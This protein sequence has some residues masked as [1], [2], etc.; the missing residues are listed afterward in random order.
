MRELVITLLVVCGLMAPGL[1]ITQNSSCLPPYCYRVYSEAEIDGFLFERAQLKTLETAQYSFMHDSIYAWYNG[2]EYERAIDSLNAWENCLIEEGD[3]NSL[4]YLV[5]VYDLSEAF[6]KMGEYRLADYYYRR[7]EKISSSEKHVERIKHLLVANRLVL[8]TKTFDPALS[9]LLSGFVRNSSLDN[10]TSNL[11]EEVPFGAT[12]FQEKEAFLQVIE[13]VQILKNQIDLINKEHKSPV[14][15][16]LS[17][18]HGLA[19]EMMTLMVSPSPTEGKEIAKKTVSIWAKTKDLYKWDRMYFSIAPLACLSL[20]LNG[21]PLQSIELITECVDRY[22]SIPGPERKYVYGYLKFPELFQLEFIRVIALTQSGEGSPLNLLKELRRKYA[23]QISELNSEL[24]ETYLDYQT[25]NLVYSYSERLEDID[26]AIYYLETGM[27]K[28][29]EKLAMQVVEKEAISASNEM[30]KFVRLGM[31]VC[32]YTYNLDIPWD[33]K[34]QYFN[35]AIRFFNKGVNLWLIRQGNFQDMDGLGITMSKEYQKIEELKYYELELNKKLLKGEGDQEYLRAEL[36]SCQIKQHGLWETIALENPFLRDFLL[37]SPEVHTNSIQSTL[38]SNE[39]ILLLYEMDG[40]IHKLTIQKDT[41]RFDTS[42]FPV[43]SEFLPFYQ[44]D[45]LT[46]QMIDQSSPD[47]LRIQA[48]Q[49][50]TKAVWPFK[51]STEKDLPYKVWVI[52]VGDLWGVPF[53]ALTYPNDDPIQDPDYLLYHHEISFLP[54]FQYWKL[55]PND[56]PFSD[57]VCIVPGYANGQDTEATAHAYPAID[58]FY[59]RPTEHLLELAHSLANDFDFQVLT[60]SNT[61]PLNVL[62]LMQNAGFIYLGAHASGDR[63]NLLSSFFSL[64]PAGLEP[65]TGQLH[66]FEIYNNRIAAELVVLAGCNSGIGRHSYG[67]GLLSTARAFIAAGSRSVVMAQWEAD[68]VATAAIHRD[69]IQM[70]MDGQ[71]K[72]SALREA[73]LNYLRNAGSLRMKAPYYWAAFQ[74][75]GDDAPLPAKLKSSGSNLWIYLPIG[76]LG[77]FIMFWMIRKRKRREE[78]YS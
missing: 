39:A 27:A 51:N 62:N 50:L 31:Q 33:K 47:S 4:D 40:V 30:A 3:T 77:A 19:I 69:F 73:K 14:L 25:A 34:L 72:S 55:P 70:L 16:S 65:T 20:T 53:D 44:L 59:Q 9:V 29:Q 61:T 48:N 2:R 76:V 21:A 52:P 67:E 8:E 42:S 74:L 35:Q 45:D 28:L 10:P 1:G 54:G 22:Y 17:G 71:S 78:S 24:I 56:S 68:E 12:D 18:Y 5:V 46:N 64:Y 38:N 7:G 63:E 36:A 60:D 49:R 11:L 57:K 26:S 32:N 15:Y 58:Y 6:Y 13:G 41:L 75:M 23:K 43:P 66:T 37:Q